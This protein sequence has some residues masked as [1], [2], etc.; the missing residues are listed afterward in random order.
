MNHDRTRPSGQVRVLLAGAAA[1]AALGPG[2][3]AQGQSPE[4]E[5]RGIEAVAGV[6]IGHRTLSERPTGCTVIW[7]PGGAVGGVDV[8]GGAPGTVETDLLDPV[9]TV[10]VVHGLFLSGGS[11]FGLAVR[12]GL[13]RAL[14]ER[15]IG[16]KVGS[17]NVPIVAGAIIYDLGLE[18]ETKVRPGPECGY[19]ASEMAAERMARAES[20]NP[21][22]PALVG[23]VGA[24]AGATVGKLM[25]AER[26]MAGG[27][28]NF[29]IRMENGLVVAAAVVVNSVGDVIDPGTGEVVA[30]IRDPASG[31]LLDARLVLRGRAAPG[32]NAA[33]AGAALTSLPGANTTIAVVA[34]N[35]V[36][37][38]AQATKVAQMAQDGI[39]R[40]IYPAHTPSDGD[41]V[42][43]L[44]TGTLES[45]AD[46]MLVGALAADALAR[47]IVQAVRTANYPAGG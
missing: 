24:G 38:K 40:A 39:A 42:F 47:A 17:K 9:N 37:T 36:L 27:F 33:G 7:V 12:D 3:T 2:A 5:D 10:S 6:A 23:R 46:V 31:E 11:A 29:A 22:P 19:E 30:G 16:F 8:R 43:S 1:F 35:A 4:N 13:V 20:E 28:G 18:G 41:T 32:R 26:A 45:G 14:D 25:G 21:P 15:D 44:A 34:T